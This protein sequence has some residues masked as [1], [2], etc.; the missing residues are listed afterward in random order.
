MPVVLVRHAHALSR[1][2]WE[3]EDRDRELSAKG[4]R[5]A[6]ML[7]PVLESMAPGRILSS[8]FLR[9]LDTVRPLA[10][11]LG[12]PVESECTLAEGEG[13]S[14]LSLIDDL[15]SDSPVLCSHGDVIPEI[16]AALARRDGLDLG[17]VPRWEKASVWVLE[18]EDGTGR[19]YRATYLPPP[20]RG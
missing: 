16:L 18:P 12:R 11:A 7:V 10:A 19:F 2:R 15:A 4:R 1:D 6:E 17:A 3:G 9:C 14:A 20:D 8:P 13:R 5:Q